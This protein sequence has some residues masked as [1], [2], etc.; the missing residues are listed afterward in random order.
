MKGMKNT[1]SQGRYPPTEGQGHEA[2]IVAQ[3]AGEDDVTS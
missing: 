3:A 1:R 2:A